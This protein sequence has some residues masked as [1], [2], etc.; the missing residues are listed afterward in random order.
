M[1][2]APVSGFSGPGSRPGRGH[3]VVFLG[4]TLTVLLPKQVCK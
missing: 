3:G 2:G 1:V 4:L